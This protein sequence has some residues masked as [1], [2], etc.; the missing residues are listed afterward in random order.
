MIIFWVVWAV[1]LALI[2]AYG[3]VL[4]YGAPYF[5]TL[6][7]EVEASLDLIDLQP[8]Q[9]IYDLGCGDG[10]LLRAAARRGIKAVGYELNPFM[11]LISWVGTLRYRRLVKVRMLNFWL[12]DLSEADG[13]FVFLIGHFMQRL[14]DKFAE[15]LRPG[16]KVVSHAFQ[17]PGKKPIKK[18][19]ALFLYKY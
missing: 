5:P 1:G 10:R 19:G 18:H 17:I 2:L 4:I 7:K 15:N 11:A 12:A 16:T 6:S 13:V 3:A 9:V 8:G 14:S